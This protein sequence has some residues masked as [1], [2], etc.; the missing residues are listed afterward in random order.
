[1]TACCHVCWRR[2]PTSDDWVVWKHRDTAGNQCPMGG[3]IYPIED[4]EEAA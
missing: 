3:H 2:V 1:M 4:R